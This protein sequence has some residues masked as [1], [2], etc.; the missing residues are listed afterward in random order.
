MARTSDLVTLRVQVLQ[1]E[2]A[3]DGLLEQLL[4]H[5]ADHGKGGHR[6]QRKATNVIAQ[7][8]LNTHKRMH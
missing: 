8:D 7:R 6:G 4:E 3:L 1:V 5:G 2:A